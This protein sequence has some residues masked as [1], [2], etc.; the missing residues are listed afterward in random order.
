MDVGDWL[1]S[2][3]LGQYE[4]VF[5]QSEIDEEVLPELTDAD[6]E[7]LGVPLGHR[8][9]LLKGDLKSGLARA[10]DAAPAPRACP[11]GN[12]YGRATPTDGDV[13]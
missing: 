10:T 3:G 12:R 11:N 5:R 4:A 8:K 1:R 2:L 6:L 9:R 7:K 13:L